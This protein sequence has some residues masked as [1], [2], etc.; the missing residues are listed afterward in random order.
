M[1]SIELNEPFEVFYDGACSICTKE[2]NVIRRL[3]KN[4]RIVF[5]D[6]VAPD[7]DAEGSVGLSYETLMDEIHG[8]FANGEV[9]TGVEVFRQLYGRV[10]LKWAIGATRLFG[11]RHALDAGYVLFAKNRLRLTGRCID[12]QCVVPS[13]MEPPSPAQGS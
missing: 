13:S 12:D 10:G 9:V 3:D 6:I 2:I 4:D 8:R 11:V 5:T 7:F 1:R